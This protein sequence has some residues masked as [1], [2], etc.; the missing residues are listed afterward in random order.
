MCWNSGVIILVL[1]STTLPA[2]I[3]AKRKVGGRVYCASVCMVIS[4][5]AEAHQTG[6]APFSAQSIS[7][8]WCG[9]TGCRKPGL[10]NLSPGW[11]PFPRRGT[12]EETTRLRYFEWQHVEDGV[13]RRLVR[14]LVS[15]CSSVLCCDERSASFV[16]TTLYVDPNKGHR[17]AV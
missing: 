2:A 5:V 3:R 7:S 15:I 6:V 12:A 8:A 9:S 1:Y 13:S 14:I 11:I 4:H 10:R 17:S 16:R